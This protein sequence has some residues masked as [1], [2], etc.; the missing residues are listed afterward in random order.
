VATVSACALIG[1]RVAFGSFTQRGT[2][3]QRSA[4][5]W[6]APVSGWRRT[7]SASWVGAMFHDGGRLGSGLTVSKTS[8]TSPGTRACR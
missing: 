1:W 4:P 7:T 8:A 5:R 3:P 6:R 2:K